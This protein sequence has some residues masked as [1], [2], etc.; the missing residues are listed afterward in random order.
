VS[1]S[2]RRATRGEH[3]TRSTDGDEQSPP[4]PAAVA[5]EVGGTA[6]REVVGNRAR[7]NQRVLVSFGLHRVR[8]RVTDL[9]PCRLD[10]SMFP[11]VEASLADALD[12]MYAE[13]NMEADVK[14]VGSSPRTD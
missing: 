11:S 2:G 9:H 4:S 7:G 5:S 14:P 13:V 1:K 8:V 6:G 3:A 10:E 12:A